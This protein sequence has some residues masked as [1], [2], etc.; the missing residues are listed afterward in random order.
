MPTSPKGPKRLIGVPK[1]LKGMPKSFKGMPR[2]PKGY[3]KGH[4][5]EN[6]GYPNAPM[7]MKALRSFPLGGPWHFLHV[8]FYALLLA[9]NSHTPNLIWTRIGS[10]LW[11]NRTW[12][13][14]ALPNDPSPYVIGYVVALPFRGMAS[15]CTPVH[16]HYVNHD[17][18][19]THTHTPTPTSSPAELNPPRKSPIACSWVLLAAVVAPCSWLL[20]LAA[21]ASRLLLL[22]AGRSW[23][24]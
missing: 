24:V 8:G 23:C 14:F 2:S 4:A 20:L 3:A 7:F 16:T 13:S 10:D 22:V 12:F 5:K 18:T 1:K 19:H 6:K 9:L 11:K 17:R 15:F 21:S